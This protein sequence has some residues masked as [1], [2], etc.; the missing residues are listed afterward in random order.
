MVYTPVE[1]IAG[2][3]VLCGLLKMLMLLF[4]KKGWFKFANQVYGNPRNMKILFC[5]LALVIL[6]FLLLELS[7]V[8][9]MAVVAFTVMLI[10]A[11]L[12]EYSAEVKAMVKK[13]EKKKLSGFQAGFLVVWIILLVWT[14][15]ELLI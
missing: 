6:Y 5:I 1:V 4:N 3:F 14:L 13:F 12:M 9:I 7:I 2:I 8:Q 11:D 10:G 15:V